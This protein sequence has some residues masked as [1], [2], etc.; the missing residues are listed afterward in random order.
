MTP[1]PIL[2]SFRRCPYAM[3]ARMAIAAAEIACEMREIILRN[4]PA[5]MLAASAKG[6]VPVLVLPD[7]AVIDESLAVMDWALRQNDPFDWL[8]GDANV[9]AA[10]I[11]ENDGPFKHHLDRYKYS[12]RYEGTD[13]EEH[14]RKGALFLETLIDR[15]G[16][17]THL[18]ENRAT[19]AD[20]AIFPFVRQFRIADPDWFNKTFEG[21]LA[22]WLDRCVNA[23]TFIR[24]MKKYTLWAPGDALVVFPP[25]RDGAAA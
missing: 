22:R 11:A 3:R 7:G 23:P 14:R 20:I 8:A 13:K 15:L 1:L 17:K 18:I 25:S 6:T 21:P 24:I 9:T 4:K 5:E 10:L 12:T 16:D 2:Y 19:L